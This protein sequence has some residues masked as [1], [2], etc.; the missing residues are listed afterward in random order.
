MEFLTNEKDKLT[1]VE[2][3]KVF[4]SE[5]DN[6]YKAVKNTKEK[7]SCDLIYLAIGFEGADPSLIPSLELNEKGNL[8]TSE[9]SEYMIDS[10]G[11]FAVVTQ[12][13]ANL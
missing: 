8:K 2:V 6:T 1:G 7:I 10:K 5:K 9:N 3:E 11:I 12:E 13:K 4:W